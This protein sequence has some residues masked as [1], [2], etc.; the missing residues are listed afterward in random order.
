MGRKVDEAVKEWKRK[1]KSKIRSAAGQDPIDTT[2]KL[3]EHALKHQLQLAP[4]A[5]LPVEPLPKNLDDTDRIATEMFGI[6][7]VASETIGREEMRPSHVLFTLAS[8]S[9]QWVDDRLYGKKSKCWTLLERRGGRWSP[10]PAWP[11]SKML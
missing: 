11:S 10:S 1:R 8:P 6:S 2:P 4:G 3:A 9:R 7:D 5:K